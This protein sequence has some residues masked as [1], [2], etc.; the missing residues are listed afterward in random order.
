LDE[1][2]VANLNGGPLAGTRNRIINGDHGDLTRPIQHQ[3]ATPG[4]LTASRCSSKTALMLPS[5]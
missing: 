1:V 3:P 4:G 5:T 2:Q